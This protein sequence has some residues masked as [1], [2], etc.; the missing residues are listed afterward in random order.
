VGS[1]TQSD[2]PSAAN[3]RGAAG[4]PT[5]ILLSILAPAGK[6]ADDEGA[7]LVDADGDA[8]MAVGL[9][10]DA[11][12]EVGDVGLDEG[13]VEDAAQAP[14]EIETMAAMPAFT[15]TDA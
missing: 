11:L 12:A 4:S 14:N 2:W 13:L 10:A 1:W 3:Q 15:T 7:A 5:W 8:T 6:D 9:V